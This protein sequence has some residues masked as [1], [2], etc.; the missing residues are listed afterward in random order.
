MTYTMLKIPDLPTTITDN[1]TLLLELLVSTATTI[2]ATIKSTFATRFSPHGVSAIVAIAESHIAV[3]TF[4][5]VGIAQ[6]E[7]AT[8]SDT[9]DVVLGINHIITQLVNGDQSNC[10][11]RKLVL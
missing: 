7:I 3:H 9:M 1:E 11:L 4:P 2:N 6:F 8:C 5:E 10:S